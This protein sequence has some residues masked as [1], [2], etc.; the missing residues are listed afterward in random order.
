MA[1]GGSVRTIYVN[2][3]TADA[4]LTISAV[5]QGNK[6]YVKDGAGRLV[7]SGANLATGTF[8]ITSGPLQ[9]QNASALSLASSV[10]VSSGGAL[11]FAGGV[12]FNAF[13]LTLNGSGVS[14]S[15]AVLNVSGTN[16]LAVRSPSPPPPRSARIAEG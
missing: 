12:A 14:G 15:G 1:D 5:M 8:T 10:T 9:I 16:T 2:D 7:L 6:G 11:E 13:P 4:D 3:G